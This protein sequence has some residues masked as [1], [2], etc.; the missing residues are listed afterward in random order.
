M[1][2]HAASIRLRR[3]IESGKIRRDCQCIHVLK[4]D[5]GH[6]KCPCPKPKASKDPKAPKG[7]PA[8]QCNCSPITQ[9]EILLSLGIDESEIPKFQDPLHWLHF[10][11]PQGMQDLKD[12]GLYTDW[13]RS[14]ITTEVNPFYDSFIKWQ[15]NTLREKNKVNFGKR[16]TIFSETDG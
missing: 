12:F 7:A 13:R 8:V 10:F 6:T 15:F 4:D 16:Y 2:I 11:P 3:E 5:K 9:Y 14:F 1:P